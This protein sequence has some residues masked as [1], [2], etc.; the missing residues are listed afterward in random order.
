MPPEI[1]H[2]AVASN[3]A[4]AAMFDTHFL[5]RHRF[6]FKRV[7][8]A[9]HRKFRRIL[10]DC[11]ICQKH[12]RTNSLILRTFEQPLP[13]FVCIVICCVFLSAVCLAE[14]IIRVSQEEMYL[15]QYNLAFSHP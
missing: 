7:P 3:A 6:V 13:D 8:Q 14:H 5:L 10:R 11:I 12:N 4:F 15:M 1:T 9:F 2:Q